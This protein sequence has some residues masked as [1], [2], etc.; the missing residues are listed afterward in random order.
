M[1]THKKKMSLQYFLPQLPFVMTSS[2]ESNIS[3][4]TVVTLDYSPTVYRRIYHLLSK[5]THI[6][7]HES[8]SH[9]CWFDHVWFRFSWF[10]PVCHVFFVVFFHLDALTTTPK[11]TTTTTT[12]S[13]TTSPPDIIQG[14]VWPP[15][16]CSTWPCLCVRVDEREMDRPPAASQAW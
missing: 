3:F 13:A 10:F 1:F 12:I 4:C 14:M 11:P 2:A 5:A 8:V 7:Q 15:S 9:C 16:T 6:T